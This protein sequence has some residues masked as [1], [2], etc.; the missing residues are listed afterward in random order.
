MTVKEYLGQIKRIDKKIW[1]LM[2]TRDLLIS[3]AFQNQ[4]PQL[5]KDKV[6]SSTTGSAMSQA[7]D[8]YV[9]IEREIERLDK[10]YAEVMWTIVKQINELDDPKYIQL[11]YLKYVEYKR[12]EDIA[13]I[14]VKTSGELYNYEY[15]KRMHGWA[16]EAFRR[17]F[18]YVTSMSPIH[19]V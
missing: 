17:K 10:R 4:S 8:R 11:L 15:V 3:R 18:P 12:L 16:L 13:C 14:M 19:D 6:Q 1:N 9:D 5:V 2:E 7:I